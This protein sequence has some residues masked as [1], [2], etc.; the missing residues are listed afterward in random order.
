MRLASAAR[1]F[2][3]EQVYDAYTGD[4]LFDCQFSS[5]DDSSSSG[6]TARRRVLSV[7][8][9]KTLPPRGV[10]SIFGDVWV[11][12]DNNIDGFN[13]RAI[14]GNFNLKK[15][16]G[17]FTILTPAQACLNSAGIDA[18]AHTTYFKDT[19]D[20]TSSGD[21]DGFWNIFFSA[22]EVIAKGTFLRLG[23]VLYRARNSYISEDKF[24]LSQCDALDPN[25]AKSVV[26][27]VNGTFDIITDSYPTVSVAT[28]GIALEMP[29]LYKLNDSAESLQAAG[30]FTL[31]V[32]KS[33]I[34][35]TVGS[36][37]TMDG[38]KWRVIAFASEV[39]AW[40]LHAR[41]T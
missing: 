11:G 21:L 12:G 26:F 1:R 15:S 20:P 9:T 7:D 30:D 39:D 2:D 24:R 25:S 38:L 5:F 16:S 27:T 41:R 3:R 8:P 37:F 13:G 35:P 31:L 28:T 14:R 10:V 23:S 6:A 22:T 34:T 29:K 18:H 4:Y 32:A 40:N 17:L 36:T 19:M 33:A